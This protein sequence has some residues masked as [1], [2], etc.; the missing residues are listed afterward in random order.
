MHFPFFCCGFCL[1]LNKGNVVFGMELLFSLRGKR[2]K[3][4]ISLFMMCVLLIFI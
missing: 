4:C 1:F 3:T 2:S